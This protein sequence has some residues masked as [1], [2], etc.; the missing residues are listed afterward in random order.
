MVAYQGR[1][2]NVV[3]KLLSALLRQSQI[4]NI[5]MITQDSSRGFIKIN[6]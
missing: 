4:L 3:E 2:S 5:K 1:P 6:T